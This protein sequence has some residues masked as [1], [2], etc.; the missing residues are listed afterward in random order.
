MLIIGKGSI[1]EKVRHEKVVR[2]S[3]EQHVGIVE[4]TYRP[5]GATRGDYEFLRRQDKVLNDYRRFKNPQ[6]REKIKQEYFGRESEQRR[7][8]G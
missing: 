6:D 1:E 8:A 3:I 4:G 7:R 2:K 5:K